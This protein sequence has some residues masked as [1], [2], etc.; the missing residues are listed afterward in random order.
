[1]SGKTEPKV[2]TRTFQETVVE[3]QEILKSTLEGKD[4]EYLRITEH[5]T[6]K[7]NKLA[8]RVNIIDFKPFDT[9]YKNIVK[10]NSSEPEQLSA[11]WVKYEETSTR[12]VGAK[13]E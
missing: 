13:E 7:F 10:R 4:D 5:W 11:C 2:V 9:E 8:K 1:M 12:V 6:D 3:V